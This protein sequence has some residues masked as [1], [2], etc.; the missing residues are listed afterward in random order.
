M[1]F[2]RRPST[3]R[4]LFH[5]LHGCLGAR[6]ICSILLRLNITDSS[7][8]TA[9]FFSVE[10]SEVYKMVWATVIVCILTGH[11]RTSIVRTF[12]EG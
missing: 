3:A 2:V 4:T 7:S 1:A 5:P 9:Q 6:V 12:T 10:G 8:T 11:S